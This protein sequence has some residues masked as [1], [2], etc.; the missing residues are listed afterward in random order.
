VLAL[1]ASDVN[2]PEP[3]PAIGLQELEEMEASV[4]AGMND[5]LNTPQVAAALS[6][7]LKVMNEL[8]HT[9]KVSKISR[10]AS[11]ETTS[12]AKIS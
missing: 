12:N 6:T 8:L 4:N 9:K 7:P 5:D 3:A 2:A 11:F 10:L 1:A